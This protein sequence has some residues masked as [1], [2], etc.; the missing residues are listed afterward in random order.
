MRA[1]LCYSLR[2]FLGNKTNVASELIST[3]PRLLITVTCAST[4]VY[5]VALAAR[6]VKDML[7]KKM[8]LL[9]QTTPLIWFIFVNNLTCMPEEVMSFS[10][11]QK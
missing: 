11:S 8:L 1:V 2:L 3:P 9:I 4:A 6:L 10:K 5:A 7:R